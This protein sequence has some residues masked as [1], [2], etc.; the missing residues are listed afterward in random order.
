MVKVMKAFYANLYGGELTISP[1]QPEFP[2]R[3]EETT[4]TELMNI[5]VNSN[6]KNAYA[7]VQNKVSAT[8]ES[9]NTWYVSI[10]GTFKNNFAENGLGFVW[11]RVFI[12]E[13]AN[14]EQAIQNVYE[15]LKSSPINIIF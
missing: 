2:N 9:G 1:G 6:N 13:A 7:C 5:L 11:N 12:T 10:D 15:E 3:S 4:I 8:I 14:S